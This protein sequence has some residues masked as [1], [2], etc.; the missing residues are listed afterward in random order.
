[1]PEPPKPE[2]PKPV[3]AAPKPAPAVTGQP[4]TV[5]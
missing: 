3:V 4:Q 1:V 2:P 5:R